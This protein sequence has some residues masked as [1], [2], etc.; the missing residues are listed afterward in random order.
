L[1]DFDGTDEYIAARYGL[2][3]GAHQGMSLLIDYA[4]NDVYTSTG[5]TY[6]CGCAWDMCICLFIDAAGDDTYRLE[7]SGGFGRADHSAWGVFVDR[8]GKDRYV[9]SG[10][11]QS[12]DNSLAVFFDGAGADD[13]KAAAAIGD[14][15]PADRQTRVH[16]MG[17]LFVDR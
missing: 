16:P 7:R 5:P 17:G 9:G 4:G 3:A 2:A 10:F 8:A 6:N 15:K 11:G 1:L 13:Y 14:F 12:T